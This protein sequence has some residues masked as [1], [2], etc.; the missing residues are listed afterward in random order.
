MLRIWA[1]PLI[2]RIAGRGGIVGEIAI[3]LTDDDLF[4]PT[5]HEKKAIQTYPE[6]VLLYAPCQ[7]DD[8]RSGSA[9]RKC[10]RLSNAKI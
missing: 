2:I 1:A 4:H 6:D 3:E 10:D 5:S 8:E 9:Q 7:E